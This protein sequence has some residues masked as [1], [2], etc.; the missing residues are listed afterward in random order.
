MSSDSSEALSALGRQV[1]DIIEAGAEWPELARK[2]DVAEYKRDD[3]AET[4]GTVAGGC[5]RERSRIADWGGT[6]QPIDGGG[7]VA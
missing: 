2:L 5:S 4:A 1:R 6:P 3:H 7:Q